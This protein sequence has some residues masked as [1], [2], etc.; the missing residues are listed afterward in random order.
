M[1]PVIGILSHIGTAKSPLGSSSLGNSYVVSIEKAGGIPI[2]LPCYVNEANMDTYLN[3]CDGFLFSGGIDISPSYYNEEPHLKLGATDLT[4]DKGQLTF[5]KKILDHN[6]PVL[7]ICRGHQVLTVASG[8]TLYQD[9]SE[10]EGTYIKHFQETENGDYSH[11]VYFEPESILY[12]M[13]GEWTYG[14]SYH[15]QATRTTGPD[16]KVIARS[17]DQIIEAIQIESKRFAL[18]IQWHPEAMFSHGN[19]SMRSIFEAFVNACRH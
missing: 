11:K 10:H 5:M 7:G 8:G 14:N 19:E 2:I 12:D 3:L 1:K 6:I 18:G 4:L 15:H 16:T 13:F 17:E 9:L